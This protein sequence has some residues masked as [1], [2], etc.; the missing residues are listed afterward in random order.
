MANLLN[1]NIKYQHTITNKRWWES[2]ENW[3]LSSASGLN[4]I[5]YP[6]SLNSSKL[7]SCRNGIYNR[8]N[9]LGHIFPV[10][11]QSFFFHLVPCAILPLLLLLSRSTS[12]VF[13]WNPSWVL[14][15]C[16]RILTLYLILTNAKIS[17]QNSPLVTNRP[18]APTLLVLVKGNRTKT[19]SPT[20]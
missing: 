6:W 3:K 12:D 1:K 11:S 16:E 15:P 19:V 4:E 9:G 7:S 10:F 17:L 5:S 13:D 8:K 18:L 2:A 14:L 20:E